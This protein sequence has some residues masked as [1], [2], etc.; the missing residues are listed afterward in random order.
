MDAPLFRQGP[1][2]V[3]RLFDQ[4]VQAQQFGLELLPSAVDIHQGEQVPHDGVQPVDL[5]IDVPQKFRLHL[6]I[7]HILVLQGLDQ[8]LHGGQRGFELVGGVGYELVA[9]L[10]Q[11]F[12][13]LAHHVESL[14]QLGILVVPPHGDPAAQIAVGHPGDAG[15]KFFDRPG[16][17]A[18][19]QYRHRQHCQGHQHQPH[20]HAQCIRVRLSNTSRA[21]DKYSTT[22]ASRPSTGMGAVYTPIRASP[23]AEK[24][25]LR[26]KVLLLLRKS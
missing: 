14:R 18:G 25:R 10:I 9:G 24:L 21:S 26:K 3:R 8:D 23:R 2:A 16:E 22:P 4:F 7:V 1:Q 11:P 5:R 20:R 6:G 19:Y 13:P 17:Q 12:Q 15:R